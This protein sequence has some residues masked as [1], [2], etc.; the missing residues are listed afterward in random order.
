MR[1]RL[2]RP[3]LLHQLQLPAHGAVPQLRPAFRPGGQARRR[4][5]G[6]WHHRPA[7]HGHPR[8]T[9]VGVPPG[10]VEGRRVRPA[11]QALSPSGTRQQDMQVSVIYGIDYKP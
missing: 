1:A 9:G 7:G 8:A 3:E 11:D 10:H 6:G 2:R 4:N 5:V